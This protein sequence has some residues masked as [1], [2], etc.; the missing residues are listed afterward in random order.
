M[1]KLHGKMFE[2]RLK[3]CYHR[4]GVTVESIKS[5]KMLALSKQANK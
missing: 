2:F 4:N 1:H 5:N 3:R